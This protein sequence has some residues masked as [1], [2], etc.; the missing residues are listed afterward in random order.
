LIDPFLFHL[1]SPLSLVFVSISLLAKLGSG[2]PSALRRFA[3]G[4]MSEHETALLYQTAQQF[5]LSVASK[6][7]NMKIDA[8]PFCSLVSW[9]E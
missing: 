1:F 7:V 8:S 3:D 5:A 6:K 2:A 9:T 4:R